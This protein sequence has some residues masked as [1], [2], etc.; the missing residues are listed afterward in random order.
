MLIGCKANNATGYL[1]SGEY[2]LDAVITH[3]GRMVALVII[4]C[5]ARQYNYVRKSGDTVLGYF[6]VHIKIY[7]YFAAS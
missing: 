1:D 7:Y 4:P 2:H 3:F 6:Y 5:S